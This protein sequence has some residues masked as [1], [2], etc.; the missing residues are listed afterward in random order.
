MGKKAK[1]NTALSVFGVIMATLLLSGGALALVRSQQET[2]TLSGLDWTPGLFA[3][4][5]GEL[6]EAAEGEDEVKIDMTGMHTS[7]YFKL[8]GVKVTV[9]EG[10][11]LTYRMNIYDKDKKFLESHT[12]D[13]NFDM[14]Y[15]DM[16]DFED[17]YPEYGIWRN[18]MYAKNKTGYL[19]DIELVEVEDGNGNGK[20]AVKATTTSAT[21]YFGFNAEYMDFIFTNTNATALEFKIFT[22]NEVLFLAQ[23]CYEHKTG[24]ST[25]SDAYVTTAYNDAGYHTVQISKDYYTDY[26][27]NRASEDTPA[28][29]RFQMRENADATSNVQAGA[30]IYIDDVCAKSDDKN[31]SLAGEYVRFEVIPVAEVTVDEE[32]GEETVAE[33]EDLNFFTK[34]ALASKIQIE[35]AKD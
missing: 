10:A 20:F 1:R 24:A 3:T 32:T 27:E 35:V 33:L 16:V 28:V 23:T 8:E 29:F 14:T 21:S 18:T 4:G 2:R 30:T 22:K 13:S 17:G 26:K 25:N 6:P 5:T 31:L 7:E 19:S 15:V 11:N 34:L 12:F 9:A